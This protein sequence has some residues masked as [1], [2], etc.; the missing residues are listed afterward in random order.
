MADVV[1]PTDTDV[2]EDVIPDAVNLKP[3]NSR[4]SKDW[5]ANFATNFAIFL[6]ELA[7]LLAFLHW[8]QPKKPQRLSEMQM[9][10]V[11]AQAGGKVEMRTRD[12]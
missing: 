9:Q 12:D 6:V 2:W 1:D 11:Q 10:E 7:G 5:M 8:T 3:S 4:I